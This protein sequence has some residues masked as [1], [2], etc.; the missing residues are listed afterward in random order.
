MAFRRVVTTEIDGRSVLV[1]DEVVPTI[2]A[3]ATQAEMIWRGDPPPDI[4]ND[5]KIDETI[6]FPAPGGVWLATWILGAGKSAVAENDLFEL[7][8]ERR[9]FHQTDTIDINFVERGSV[10]LEVDDGSIELTAG[11]VAIV[12]G[13]MHAWHNRGTEEVR[14]IVTMIGAARTS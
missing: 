6:A 7:S 9:G 1:S 8:K 5:G 10:V 13:N 4:P 2:D 3:G 14:V 11:D 12:N